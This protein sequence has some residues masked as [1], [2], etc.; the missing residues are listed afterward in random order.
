MARVAQAGRGEF[1]MLRVLH[2]N[3]ECCARRRCSL[4]LFAR[5]QGGN[6]L[7]HGWMRSGRRSCAPSL[8]EI[9]RSDLLWS[10]RSVWVICRD[11]APSSAIWGTCSAWRVSR[12][13][14]VPF[15]PIA[16]AGRVWKPCIGSSCRFSWVILIAGYRWGS[17]GWAA[18]SHRKT[19]EAYARGA[20]RDEIVPLEVEDPI[21]DED[22]NWLDQETGA[23]KKEPADATETEGTGRKWHLRYTRQPANASRRGN[24]PPMLVVPNRLATMA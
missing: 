16:N 20:Y 7:P 10:R 24:W 5:W 4:P 21:Y 13:R 22:G 14:L 1:S 15:I 11:G 17:N 12:S 2:G 9:R 18:E 19:D 23:I 8:T 3:P 6:W